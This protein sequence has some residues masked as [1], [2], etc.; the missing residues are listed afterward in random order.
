MILVWLGAVLIGL[1][2]GL[3]GSGGS[4]LTV[5]VLIY[6]VGEPEKL[7][8]AESLAIVGGISLFGAIPYVLQKKVDW[9]SFLWFGVPGVVG[10][11]LG[12]ALS[13]YLSGTI[14]LLLFATVMLIAAVM[15]FKGKHKKTKTSA[16]ESPENYQDNS[17][18]TEGQ[19]KKNPI[20]IILEG[21]SV[22]VLTGIVGVGGGFLII[23]ALVLLGG[24]PMHIAVGTS[25]LIIFIKSFAGFYKYLQIMSEQ[26]ISIHWDLILIFT[27]IGILGSLFGARLGKK[28]SNELLRK[29]FAVFLIFMGIYVLFSNI[30]KI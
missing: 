10:T 22:G 16:N 15:M 14:Q 3:L 5:P 6:F 9:Y 21:L 20:I 19:T 1:S 28:I 7:A 13:K 4:I 27:A 23:P 24:L 30:G 18:K 11:Y 12:A 17:Q 8:I 2:L 26:N 29:Y 25:L